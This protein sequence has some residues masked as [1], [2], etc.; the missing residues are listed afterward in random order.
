MHVVEQ[1][2]QDADPIVEY[3]IALQA[4]QAE[5]EVEPVFGLYLP[6]AHFVQRVAPAAEYEPFG[7]MV[8]V[9]LSK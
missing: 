8:Q 2:L 1:A 9:L 4:K 3:V 5:E 7:Q 6:A